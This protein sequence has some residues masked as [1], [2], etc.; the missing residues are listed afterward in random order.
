MASLEELKKGALV[1]G[2]PP[3]CLITTAHGE[4]PR[5][6]TGGLF[7]EGSSAAVAKRLA[8]RSRGRLRA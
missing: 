1:R 7:G 5:Q 4:L 6:R 8:E 3:N 2:I